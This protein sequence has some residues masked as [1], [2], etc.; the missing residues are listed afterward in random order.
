DIDLGAIASRKNDTLANQTPLLESGQGVQRLPRPKR[1]LLSHLD[2]S[3]SVANAD[4]GQRHSFTFSL[5]DPSSTDSQKSSPSR[6]GAAV[7]HF[8]SPPAM[9]RDLSPRSA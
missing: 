9:R 5:K 3:G 6:V 8:P 4:D 2:R 1:E 7:F